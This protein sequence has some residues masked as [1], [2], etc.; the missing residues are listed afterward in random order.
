MHMTNETR[1]TESEWSVVEAGARKAGL[2]DADIFALAIG[3]PAHGNIPMDWD[4]PGDVFCYFCP[5]TRSPMQ[6]ARANALHG[7]TDM[8]EL[9][10]A[11]YPAAI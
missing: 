9:E 5:D 11:G 1:L 3:C 10:S 8:G 7:Y 6:V 2:T 4:G